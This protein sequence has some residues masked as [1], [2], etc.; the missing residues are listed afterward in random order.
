MSTKGYFQLG[1]TTAEFKSVMGNP[2]KIDKWPSFSF[3]YY[4]RSKVE[5]QNGK[6]VSWE[7]KGNLKIR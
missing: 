4:E 6:V 2:D 1:S 5:I 7:N 3:W